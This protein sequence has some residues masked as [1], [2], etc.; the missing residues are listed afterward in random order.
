VSVAGRIKTTRKAGSKLIFYE[1]QGEGTSIQIMANEAAHTDTETTFAQIHSII[2][3]GDIIGVEGFPNRSKSGELSITPTAVKLLSP[4]LRVMPARDGLKDQEMRYRQRYV[5]LIANDPIRQKFIIRSQIIRY[6]RSYLD[7]SGFLEVETPMMNMIAGGAAAKPFETK[8]NDL[9]LKMFMR[10]APELYLKMLTVGGFDRVYEIGRQFRNEAIDLTHNPEFTTCE[11]Y[12]AYA[13]Y[14]DLMAITEEMVAGMVLSIKGS[15][16]LT[17]HPEGPD[18]PP[19]EIDFTPPFERIPIIE[20]LTKVLQEKGI[21]EPIPP[22][23]TFHT[24]ETKAW[25]IKLLAKLDVECSPPQTVSRMVDKLVGEYLETQA[26]TR[27]IFITEHPQ[28]MSPLAKWHRSKPG[29]TERFELFVSTKEVCNAYTELNDPVVQRERF[30]TQAADIKAG[31]D[32]AQHIDENYITALEYGLP[33]T[34]G[35]GMGIDRMSMFLTD[36]NNIKEILLFPAMKPKEEGG[37]AE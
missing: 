24:D 31:D 12:M 16:K 18:G 32:E 7:A 1:L 34:G 3:R 4:C 20:G 10:V 25:F 9:N 8:H 26:T 19:I 37:P 22:A 35:W 23:T 11:F 14:D 33:P 15:Y 36:S 29:I 17:Y 6:I 13:D 5:D 28:V 21:T 27:P 30:A 2:K